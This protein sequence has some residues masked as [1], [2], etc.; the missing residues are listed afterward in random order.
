MTRK[1]FFRLTGSTLMAAAGTAAAPAHRPNIVFILADDLG[2]GDLACYGQTRIQTPNISR[3]AAEGMRFTSTYAGST[4]CAPSR[5]CLMTG[6]HTGHARTRGNKPIDLPLRPEDPI[7]PE[8][9][10]KAGYRTGLMGKWSLGQ[11]G[12]SGYPTRKGFDDWFGFFSQLHAHEYYPEHLL[13]NEKAFLCKG[14]LGTQQKDYAPDLFTA[15]A[16]EFIGKQTA[17][18]PFFLH[19]C[20]TAPHANNELGRD[21]GNGMQVPSDA[22]YSKQPWPQQEKNFA[23]MI[24]RM[25]ADVGKLM[26]ALKS[27]GLDGNTLVIFTSDNG[28]HSEGGHEPK[29]FESSGPL[30]G[31]KR[32]MYE[33][34]IRVPAIVRWP[35]QI[36]AGAVSD[37]PWAFW[38]FLPTAAELAGVPAPAGLDGQSI[39][40]VLLGKQQK[41]HEYFYWEFHER[42]FDQAARTGNWKGVRKGPKTPIE[43]YDLSKDISERNDL[44]AQHPEVV[45]KIEEIFAAA[46]RD[47]PDWP[48]LTPAEAKKRAV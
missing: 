22:P 18:Q 44:A 10:K 16:L 14:N 17:A 34:G 4:V 42:G 2:Y 36:R 5:C 48:I 33:G 41:P 24:T 35:G 7:V 12:S 13:D 1:E 28:P 46:H 9:L 47:S 43:L 6:Y 39:V 38:D 3:L 23:A 30:R 27:K 31:I 40:P 21:T 29:F 32:D 45:R 25:D 19:V 8:V 37:F 26:D 15:R 11:L 20:Y